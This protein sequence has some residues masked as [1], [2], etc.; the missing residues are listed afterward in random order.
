MF[1]VENGERGVQATN[2]RSESGQPFER[3]STSPDM[4]GNGAQRQQ[5]PFTPRGPP[6]TGSN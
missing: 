2:V 1:D 6:R 4:G 3:A 5:R